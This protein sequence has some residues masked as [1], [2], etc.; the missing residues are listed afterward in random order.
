[1]GRGWRK[2]IQ[3]VNA[4]IWVL[5]LITLI[6]I[7]SSNDEKWP[8]LSIKCNIFL[9]LLRENR[10]LLSVFGTLRLLR[11]I[12]VILQ[13]RFLEAHC[14]GIFRQNLVDIVII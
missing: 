2:L 13:S 5:L 9:K 10:P 6:E 11:L 4:D 3:I 12:L 1:M 8:L 14:C 7:R